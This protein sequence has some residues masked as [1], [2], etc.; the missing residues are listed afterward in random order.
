[1]RRRFAVLDGVCGTDGR[2]RVDSPGSSGS[3]HREVDSGPDSTDAD[4]HHESDGNEGG[5]RSLAL[6]EAREVSF[7]SVIV[8]KVLFSE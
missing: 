3:G 6:P 8:L 4:S 7:V 1:M 5:R 2:E